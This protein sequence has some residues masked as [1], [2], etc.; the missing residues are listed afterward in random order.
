[1]NRRVALK[2]IYLIPVFCI[3]SFGAFPVQVLAQV[4]EN[5]GKAKATLSTIDTLDPG[6]YTR[7]AVPTATAKAARAN[8]T[9]AGKKAGEAKNEPAPVTANGA[10]NTATPVKPVEPE[11]IETI[12]RVEVAG[13]AR[14]QT[15]AGSSSAA[16]STG[17]VKID[18]LVANAAARYSVDSNLIFA[19]MRQESSFNPRAVSP[20][21][22]RGLMQL[23]PATAMRLGVRDIYD[24]AQNIDGGA[25]YLRFLLDT[26]DG[27][28]QLALAGYNAG[29][30]AVARY[31]N[32]IPPYRET[33]DYVQRI[34]AHYNRLR[35]GAGGQTAPSRTQPP[36]AVQLFRGVRTLSQY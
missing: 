28:V 24:P 13:G 10:A 23:M 21:G 20:K 36:P 31:G 26:F 18:Q 34:S 12:S 35:S 2:A 5:E 1:M 25:R 6:E 33:I 14:N 16:P 7:P 4:S 19:V 15:G 17:D 27:D 3:T 22:A 8:K 29:E 9:A 30:G 32:R 11:L